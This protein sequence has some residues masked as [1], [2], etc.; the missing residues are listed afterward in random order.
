MPEE[1]KARKTG[2]FSKSKQSDMLRQK[3]LGNQAF[4]SCRGKFHNLT[5]LIVEEVARGAKSPSAILRMWDEEAGQ[6]RVMANLLALLKRDR[7]DIAYKQ[8]LAALEDGGYTFPGEMLPIEATEPVTLLMLAPERTLSMIRWFL[9]CHWCEQ[10]WFVLRKQGRRDSQGRLYRTSV[11]T[12]K[13]FESFPM[14]EALSCDRMGTGR[15]PGQEFHAAYR[16]TVLETF[17]GEVVEKL[18]D[19]YCGLAWDQWHDHIEDVSSLPFAY[20]IRGEQSKVLGM[21]SREDQKRVATWRFNVPRAM[22]PYK[23]GLHP[24]GFKSAWLRENPAYRSLGASHGYEGTLLRG[25]REERESYGFAYHGHGK[26]RRYGIWFDT[27][28]DWWKDKG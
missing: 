1:Q 7:C 4:A 3:L 8:L 5:H 27:P 14:L 25:N 12:R 15:Y 9:E 22:R 19:S 16:Q 17:P 24:E 21:F 13:M 20:L 11:V 23:V 2:K 28:S 6:R 26:F 18:R 10:D